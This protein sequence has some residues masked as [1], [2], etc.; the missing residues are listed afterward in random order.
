MMYL[1]FVCYMLL[2]LA[3]VSCSY[4]E[5][6]LVTQPLHKSIMMNAVCILSKTPNYS[7]V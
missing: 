3:S 2:Y 1:T 4:I 6:S 7:L 5:K